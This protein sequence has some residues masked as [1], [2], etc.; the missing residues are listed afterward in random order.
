MRN[1]R[2]LRNTP[3]RLTIVAAACITAAPTTELRTD[4][5]ITKAVSFAI[6]EDYDKGESLDD[7]ERDFQLFDELDIRTWRGSIGWDDYEPTRGRYDFDWL[8]RF[9]ALAA[10]HGISLRPYI[11]YTPQWA[12]VSTG[13]TS[14]IWNRPP[15]DRSEWRRFVT[16]LAVAMKRHPNVVSYEIYNEENVSQWWDGSVKQ[17]AATLRD[18]SDAI[19]SVDSRTP[20]LFGGLVFP[21]SD[22]ISEACAEHRVPGLFDVLPVHAYPETWTP[23]GVTLESYAATIAPFVGEADRACG[24]KSIWINETGFATIPGRSEREQ[25]NWWVRA[26]ATFLAEPRVEHIGVYE[27]KDLALNRDAIG[28]LPNYHLGLTRTDR[29]KK[30]AF[31]TVDMLTDLLDTGR[32]TIDD[33]AATVAGDGVAAG[34]LYHHVF[35]RPDGDRV[36]IVWTRTIAARVDVTIATSAQ[37]IE[38]TID[39][40]QRPVTSL[41]QLILVGGEPRVFRLGPH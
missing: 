11:G 15:S 5:S 38:Y 25:A 16:A 4:G 13:A 32:I 29:T 3:W 23:P 24:K 27:I 1:G 7:I 20:V 33:D 31:A 37:M 6:L 26:V 28:D 40:R 10:R 18:A 19:R 17:Y 36:L 41:R 22:W 21:D 14:T 2:A 30:L 34:D 12:A 9:V 35:V 39:G 8:E